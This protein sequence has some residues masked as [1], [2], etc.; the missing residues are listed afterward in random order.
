MAVDRKI[1]FQLEKVNEKIPQS[2]KGQCLSATILRAAGPGVRHEIA[3]VRS[4]V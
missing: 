2:P 4:I 1:D 3:E